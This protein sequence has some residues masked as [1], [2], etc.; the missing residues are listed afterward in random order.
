M[1]SDFRKF[2][3]TLKMI[4]SCSGEKKEVIE[5]RL[6]S[7]MRRGWCSM[8]RISSDRAIM[9]CLMHEGSEREVHFIDAADGGYALASKPL[10]AQLKEAKLKQARADG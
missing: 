3:G 9:T 6:Q 2:D 4:V 8:A 7:S 1:A 10:K 5:E